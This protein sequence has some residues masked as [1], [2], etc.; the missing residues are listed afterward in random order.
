M[1][2]QDV[3]GLNSGISTNKTSARGWLIISFML[4]NYLKK[5]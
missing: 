5:L 3:Q 1:G 4:V 2:G